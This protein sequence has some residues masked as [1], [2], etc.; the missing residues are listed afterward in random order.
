MKTSLCISLLILL[1]A[2]TQMACKKDTPV[3]PISKMEQVREQLLNNWTT[4]AFK[5]DS[6]D[7]LTTRHKPYIILEEYGSGFNLKDDGN[8]YTHYADSLPTHETLRGSWKLLNESEIEFT[9]LVD[10]ISGS[11]R[12]PFINE[13]LKLEGDDFWM[14]EGDVEYRM[15]PLK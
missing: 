6:E 15:V 9:S 10:S 11:V 7:T 1:G 3:E 12:P 13:I 14:H 8:Y 4:I 2:T 5:F